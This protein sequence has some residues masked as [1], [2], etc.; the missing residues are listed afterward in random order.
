MRVT[1]LSYQPKPRIVS[2]PALATKPAQAPDE[3]LGD[4]RIRRL[5]S[6]AEW[7]ALPDAVRRRFSKRLAGGRTALY[8]GEIVEARISRAGWMLAQAARLIGAPLPT[9]VDIGAP[10]TVAVTE[11][12]PSGGQ[13]WTRIYGRRRGFPQVIQSSKRFRGPTGLEEYLGHGVGMALTVDVTDGALHFR[14]DHYFIE[15]LGRRIRLP[16]WLAP[17]QVTVSHIDR[18]NG[19]FVFVL[20]VRHPLLGELVHQSGRFADV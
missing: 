17:G 19:R 16:R 5:L 11:D 13:F 20:E 3:G 10:A 14:S 6:S 8:V 9:S 7:A 1:P 2:R 4:L 12:G 15:I 18:G